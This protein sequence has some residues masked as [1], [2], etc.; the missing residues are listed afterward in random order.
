MA[1]TKN[2]LIFKLKPKYLIFIEYC[3]ALYIP[4][5]FYTTE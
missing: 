3:I 1:K 5:V 2:E 4:F